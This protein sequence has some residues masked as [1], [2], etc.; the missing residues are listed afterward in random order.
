MIGEVMYFELYID[1]YWFVVCDCWCEL[2]G[3]GVGIWYDF[4]LYLVDQVLQLFGLFECVYVVFVI[5]CVGGF[6]DD[7]VYVWLDYGVC[8]V[9][10]YVSMFVVG[11]VWCFVVYGICGSLIKIGVDCQEVQLLVGF[12]FGVVGWGDDVDLFI[13]I[14]VYGY[15]Y[16]L[17]VVVG[18]QC[19]YYVVLCDV[20][21]GEVFWLVMLIEVLVVMV[22][23]DVGFVLQCEGSVLL[24]LLNDVEW[25]VFVIVCS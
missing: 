21:V 15:E 3:Q 4:G 10:V 1:C 13:V 24:L 6:S 14:D 8:Q 23:I 16:V 18:D 17:L 5:Q 7:W 9:I 25:V 2:V 22:V 20:I 19:C 12:M 11:G